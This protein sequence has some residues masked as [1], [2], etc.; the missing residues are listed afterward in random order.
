MVRLCTHHQKQFIR[1]LNDIYTEGQPGC[2]GRPVPESENMDAATCSSGCSQQSTENWKKSAP[3]SELKPLTSSDA[4]R[5]PVGLHSPLRAAGQPLEQHAEVKSMTSMENF[6]TAFK[7]DFSELSATRSRSVS[8]KDSSTQGYLTTSNSS[9]LHFHPGTRSPEGQTSGQEQEA[10][11]RKCEDDK[12]PIQGKTLADGYIAV[13]VAHVNGSEDKS[14]S[15]LGPQKN[16]SKAFPEEGWDSGFPVNSPRRAD[17]ENALQCSSN[18]SLHQDL[19][20]NEEDAR[21][22]QENH[23]HGLG[24]AKGGYH[25]HPSD[26]SPRE[27]ARDGWVASAPVPVTHKAS[28]GRSRAKAGASSVRTARKNKRAS[29]LRINDY[30]NQCDVVYISQPITECHLESQRSVSSRRTARKSTR[31]YYFN[32]ECCELPTVRTLVK[33][34]R[35]GER[36]H[37]PALSAK[38]SPARS[39]GEPSGAAQAV[40]KEADKR[41]SLRLLSKGAPPSR[42]A[43]ERAEQEPSEGGSLKSKEAAYT[44]PLLALSAPP[45]PDNAPEGGSATTQPPAIGPSAAEGS[46]ERMCQLLE[47][48]EANV[49]QQASSSADLS[50]DCEPTEDSSREATDSTP[51]S[52]PEAARGEEGSPCSEI[53]V[54]PAP[55]AGLD[56][57]PPL[58][59]PTTMDPEL[60]T[61]AD[62]VHHAEP[63]A[64]MDPEPP[65]GGDPELAGALPEEPPTS[66]DLELPAMDLETPVQPTASLETEP[67]ARVQSADVAESVPAEPE[68]AVREVQESPPEP[69]EAKPTLAELGRI[70][71]GETAPESS[72]PCERENSEGEMPPGPDTSEADAKGTVL[73]KESPEKKQKKGRRALV[74]SDRRLRS[75]Q[76]QP[77][78]EGSAEKSGSSTS[79]QLPCLQIKLSKSPGAKRFRREVHLDGAASVCFPKDC[80]H[81]TLLKNIQGPGTGSALAREPVQRGGDEN[82][83]TT[84]Q[85]YKSML[86]KEGAAEREGSSK[87]GPPA[88]ASHSKSG[89]MLEICVEAN[90]DKRSVLL[91]RESA[92]CTP[93]P[94]RS[95]EKPGDV[96]NPDN[97]VDAGKVQYKDLTDSPTGPSSKSGSKHVPSKAWKHKKL[98]LP[99]YNLRHTPTPVDTAKKNLPGKEV[100]QANPSQ[101]EE[102]SL[103]NKD[104]IDLKE[105]DT[106]AEDKPKFV[107]WCA[108]EE[109]QELI[110]DFNAQYMK[111]QKGWIQLEKEGQPAPKVKNKADKLK[112][113]W[114]SK[115]RTRK[116]RASLEVQKLSPVQMLFMKAFKL[117]NIC[118]WF[119]ET[120]ETRSLVI[121]KKLNTRLPGDVPPIKI[122]LQKYCSSS[123][124]PSSLQAERLKKHLK[125]FAATTPAKNNLKNQKLW[126]RLRENADST[127]PGDAASPNQMSPGETSS[128]E[129]GED[130]NVQPPP[131][132]P[133]QASTRILRKYSNLRGKLRAQ[134]R[135]AKNERKG[136]SAADHP[137][138]ESE[139]SRKSVC[140]NPLMSP[141]LALQV[142]ADVFPA[143]SM[144]AEAAVKG[145][146]G[147]SR[148]QEDS[149]PKAEPQP[150][151]KK[152]TL[153]EGSAVPEPSHSSSKERLPAKKGSKVKHSEGPPK[154]PAT[155]KQA[156]MERSSKL[157]KEVS[158]KQKRVPKRQLGKGRL[159]IP[160]VRENPTKRAAAPPSQEGLTKSAKPKAAGEPSTRSQKA[161]DKKPSS[162]KTLTRSM[163]K[164]QESSTSQGKRKLRANVDCSHSK[165][166][167]LD[168]K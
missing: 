56:P 26:K 114:K 9:S 157:E 119:L 143:K 102:C 61:S 54:V 164:I 33:S 167:R 124:Y 113:I 82:G 127:E 34:S 28:S 131:S 101:K 138:V 147:K 68:A 27:H 136:E 8:P 51:L 115:K 55:P 35:V 76:S 43:N 86:A 106:L 108:E 42:E 84:R 58:Q 69:G 32:G 152:R 37:G 150:G 30:D 44:E 141:K 53:Q 39:G 95:D 49:L 77:P 144:R 31:G 7:R 87:D 145:R 67:P 94:E 122:P 100:L 48:V 36:G 57:T 160:K 105:V 40:G 162:G 91:P 137:S 112:E 47:E 79:L 10:G 4:D 130:R 45:C 126:A 146:K 134:H 98:A 117:S 116:C 20:M 135:L 65:A 149:L 5:D 148:S 2:E 63:P 74:A 85:T 168:A 96:E 163:K 88:K 159:P 155:R 110:A 70:L 128:E 25:P 38:Q 142:K 80:F 133:T 41:A 151:R 103:G 99:V 29:G 64:S 139:Q 46:E 23:L 123:L 120:T 75:Q 16:S 18:A 11:V 158:L 17:K 132:L 109:N 71:A 22:K 52:P 97:A 59:L 125:K 66:T 24:K 83:I 19:E 81:K 140:I 72:R 90:S 161:A 104:P 111:V 50:G 154:A 93:V 78:A 165:R 15:C 153:R 60:P 89:E 118:R 107:E 166:T 3:C 14:D 13:K 129:A 6:S 62:L 1:V 12:A 21:P 156:A 121:V 73:S 92:S